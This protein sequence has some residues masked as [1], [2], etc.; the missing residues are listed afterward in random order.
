MPLFLCATIGTT[1][2]TA[3]DPLG[4][5]GAVAKEFGVWVHVDGAYGASACICPEYSH[6]MEGV[7][8][9][10]SFSFNPHK[11]LFTGLDCCCL[12]VKHKAALVE[13]LS[14]NAEYLRNKA[15]DS[16]QVLL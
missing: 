9:T 3:V 5:L 15:S 13:S 8:N 1:P 14:T 11:W 2:S 10:D 4:P 6:F 16:D 12:W 7:E